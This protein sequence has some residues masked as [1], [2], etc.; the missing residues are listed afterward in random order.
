MHPIARAIVAEALGRGIAATAPRDLQ[1]RSGFRVVAGED[2]ERAILERQAL[3]EALSLVVLG[4]FSFR[5]PALIGALLLAAVMPC[6]IGVVR[7]LVL[8]SCGRSPHRSRRPSMRRSP[9]FVEYRLTP[10]RGRRSVVSWVGSFA[11]LS[12]T[13]NGRHARSC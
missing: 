13:T 6:G 7:V 10:S 8:S 4:A 12:Q 11:W 5:D 2:G 1:E 3:L 9:L